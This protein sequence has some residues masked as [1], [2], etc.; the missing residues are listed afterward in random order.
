MTTDPRAPKAAEA[1][2]RDDLAAFAASLPPD[3]GSD[4]ANVA[5]GFIATR[6][7]PVIEKLLPNPWQPVSWD[8]SKSDF[9]HGPCPDTVNPA[10]WRQAGFNAQHGLY[11]VCDGF[12]QVRGF[13]TSSVTF[14]RGDVGWV[15]ID[16]LT[17]QESAAA[18]YE[19][20]TE[21]LGQRPVTAVI[22]THSHLDHYG[23]ILGVVSQERIG[24]G[25]V[26]IVAPDGFLREA[27]SENVVAAPVMGR[28]A[29]YQ[30]GMLL[31]WSEHH[32]VD[33]GLGKG[34]STGSSAL[35]PPTID[36]VETG[37][38]LVL[39]GVRVE[40][41]LTP[42]SEAPAEMHFY[43]PDHKALCMAENCTATMHNVLTLRGALV[44]DALLWSRY[45]DEALDRWGDEAELVFA[46]HG[47]PHWGGDDVREYLVNQRD[48]YRWLHD[49]AMRLTNLGFTPNEIAARI[50]L[51]PGLWAD[52]R[53]HGYY[54]TVSHNVRAVYQ[55]YL[56]FYDGHPSSLEPYEPVEAGKRYVD[57]MGGMDRLLEQAQASFE[58]GDHRWV[59]EVLRHAVF[60]DPSCE[61]ARLLQAD[62]FEQLAYRAESGPWR[63]IYLTGAQE[64]RN[65]SL[66]LESTSRPRP[67]MVAGMDLQQAFDLIAA[68]LDGPAAVA[69]SPLTVNWYV[70][71]QDTAV[72]IELSNGTMHSVPDRTYRTPDV[73]V[74]GDRAA[75]ERIIAEGT[76]LDSLLDDGSLVAEGNVTGL[77]SLFDCITPFPRFYNIIEP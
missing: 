52:W 35:V 19:L 60:A 48:L 24:A 45:I 29:M 8:L 70:T 77:R 73:M 34:V 17:T 33:Q 75:I 16:P 59:A 65:G 41:Q 38:E 69:V 56:G 47:W 58:A 43:F 39:D 25:E 49:Q 63:D 9:V 18:A 54:G 31:P 28:R 67:E 12:Y 10:L 14:I 7:E 57:F 51:P 71:D 27:V 44:R 30:F 46:S 26:P 23:G 53:C 61:E 50:D 32:H 42:E 74:R 22:Y 2:T 72:R 37:Q 6:Q 3:D 40:F 1:Q 68:S 66:T 36:I 62:A 20:V 15:V 64:L 76:T 55:R 5:R 4:A 11:E 21:H 13:D